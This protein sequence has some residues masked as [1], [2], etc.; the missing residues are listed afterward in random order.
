MPPS[1]ARQLEHGTRNWKRLCVAAGENRRVDRNRGGGTARA[2]LLSGRVQSGDHVACRVPVAHPPGRGKPPN[3][4]HPP[5]PPSANVLLAPQI[6]TRE[7]GRNFSS[8]APNRGCQQVQSHDVAPLVDGM[9]ILGFQYRT[10]GVDVSTQARETQ[11]GV[12]ILAPVFVHGVVDRVIEVGRHNLAFRYPTQAVRPLKTL[13]GQGGVK[14]LRSRIEG[15]DA[16]HGEAIRQ[17]HVRKAAAQ[18]I[19]G[20]GGESGRILLKVLQK[21]LAESRVLDGAGVDPCREGQLARL[22][23]VVIA[24][25]DR[26][27]GRDRAIEEVGLRKTERV[28][29]LEGPDF[30]LEAQSLSKP[31]EVVRG[32]VDANEITRQSA[33]AA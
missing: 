4:P 22:V 12:Q 2:C 16:A 33:H 3:R 19:A 11:G 23:E 31:E 14:S 21:E 6:K 24:L 32:V 28:K 20:K 17:A 8:V 27:A 1:R 10:E 26:E 13:E 30:N 25:K 5:A 9:E 18:R 29:L 15:L 7:G